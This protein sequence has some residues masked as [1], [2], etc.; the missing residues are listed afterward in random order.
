MGDAAFAEP[1][2]LPVR[3]VVSTTDVTLRGREEPLNDGDHN[4]AVFIAR[5]RDSPDGHVLSPKRARA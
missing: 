3:S 2:A 4:I 5:G 1:S